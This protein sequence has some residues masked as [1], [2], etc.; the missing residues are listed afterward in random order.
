[1]N[2]ISTTYRF[3]MFACGL[4]PRGGCS[5]QIVRRSN[6]IK[7]N[8]FDI[9]ASF[10]SCINVN[11]RDGMVF[12]NN[13]RCKSF[14]GFVDANDI[15]TL[16]FVRE[17]VY[18]PEH[19]SI[20][21]NGDRTIR[22]NIREFDDVEDW[23][24]E[25]DMLIGFDD[26]DVISVYSSDSENE[27]DDVTSVYSDIMD[28]QPPSKKRR[29]D[30]SV[31]VN[32][33]VREEMSDN[34]LEVYRVAL[35]EEQLFDPNSEEVLNLNFEMNELPEF[36]DVWH[37][38]DD[39]WSDLIMQNAANDFYQ[40]EDYEDISNEDFEVDLDEEVLRSFYQPY[41][42][43]STS[44]PTHFLT[45]NGNITPGVGYNMYENPSTPSADLLRQ[46]IFPD[47]DSDDNLT[48]PRFDRFMAERD[49]LYGNLVGE[50]EVYAD[51]DEFIEGV[52]NLFDLI[53]EEMED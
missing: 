20:A 11:K 32:D 33:F 22:M 52:I 29:I 46:E 40:F 24:G 48:T 27:N 53:C 17:L 51:E 28:N 10:D 21:Q 44:S 41:E 34:N 2:F 13:P 8:N 9:K 7:K 19:S 23:E 18:T 42:P 15:V 5:A 39:E 50:N 35:Q 14:L 43:D 31:C 37:E 30:D 38:L 3:S 4:Y 16:G 25:S 1:M 45:M 6:C 47:D 12:C 49:I 26:N 36:D